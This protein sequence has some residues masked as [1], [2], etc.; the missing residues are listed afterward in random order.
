MPCSCLEDLLVRPKQFKN[1]T[2][3]LDLASPHEGGAPQAGAPLTLPAGVPPQ[4]WAPHVFQGRG[5]REQ[6]TGCVHIHTDL[7]LDIHIRID[8]GLLRSRASKVNVTHRRLKCDYF[9]F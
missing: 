2:K 9:C 8:A 3:S 1:N 7:Y 4:G 6:A 5:R